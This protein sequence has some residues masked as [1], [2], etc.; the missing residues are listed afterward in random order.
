MDAK[1]VAG[2]ARD[3][4][5][6]VSSSF[7]A[8]LVIAFLFSLVAL[9]GLDSLLAGMHAERD[10]GHTIGDLASVLHPRQAEERAA[11][12]IGTWRGWQAEYRTAIGPDVI[13]PAWVAALHALIDSALLV[14]TYTL[15]LYF[16]FRGI[17]RS[18]TASEGERV[19]AR[20]AAH[21]VLTLAAFD[22][23]ENA[24][25]LVVLRD[26]WQDPSLK[27]R[28]GAEAY[29]LT[30]AAD[31]KY[32]VAV[33][34]VVA[35][36]G[37]GW[38]RF[39]RW[40]ENE[41][42]S[43]RLALSRLRLH[44]VAAILFAGVLLGH[45][46]LP[47][48]IRRWSAAQLGWAIS[49]TA[50]FAFV[51]WVS[52]GKLFTDGP[53]TKGAG[54][55]TR[56]SHPLLYFACLLV[57]VGAS[58]DAITDGLEWFPWALAIPAAFVL[59]FA[60]AG[61]ILRGV[62]LEAT[63]SVAEVPED[64]DG[65][66][67]SLI[68]PAAVVV[69]LG[70]AVFRASFAYSI[71]LE[72]WTWWVLVVI[73]SILVGGAVGLYVSVGAP[74]KPTDEHVLLRILRVPVVWSVI[75]AAVAFVILRVKVGGELNGSLLVTTG[76]FLG[77]AGWFT[78]NL[79]S[80]FSTHERKLVA[81]TI[82][83]GV[84]LL[85]LLWTWIIANPWWIA[86]EL[87]GVAILA[88]FCA[89]L[90]FGAWAVIHFSDGVPPPPAL[91]VL[92]FRHTPIVALGLVWLVLA[93]VLD[94]GGFHD[95]R[96]DRDARG[97]R[98]TL[99]E[100]W[101]CWKQKNGLE[102]RSLSTCSQPA[103]TEVADE[104]AQVTPMI[105]VATTGGGIRA[106]IWTSYV[107]DC[108][109]E[110]AVDHAT[111]RSPCVTGPRAATFRRSDD[112]FA[113]SGISGGSM[114]LASYAAYLT[115][116]HGPEPANWQATRLDADSLSASVAWWLFVE[117]PWAF[118][119]FGDVKDRAAV[120]ERG[121]ERDWRSASGLNSL[122]QPFLGLWKKPH[123]PLLLL[124]GTNVV[125]GCRFNV[126]TLDTRIAAQG[127]SDPDALERC[128]S[129]TAFDESNATTA[130]NLGTTHVRESSALAATRDLTDFL[131]GGAVDIP[132]STAALLSGRFPF[133]SPAG[134]IEQPCGNHRVSYVVDGGYL[135]TSGASPVVQ[136][137]SRLEPSILRWDRQNPK[138]CIIPFLIQID[139]GPPGRQ[140][141]SKRP[142]ELL[143]PLKGLFAS[144]IGRAADSRN[145]AALLFN[146][147][148]GT[149]T[150]RESGD[151]NPTALADRYAHFVNLAHPGPQPPLGWT[152]SAFSRE[153]LRG[154]LGQSRNVIA[155]NEVRSW[156][157]AARDGR[158][159]CK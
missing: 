45:E 132:L 91:R 92:R 14:V 43:F 110:V 111:D 31:I 122:G 139:N 82:G 156:F 117:S 55:G 47:D 89:V 88:S 143:V 63:P 10:V 20:R 151:A 6:G 87:G 65:H 115:E 3:A 138:R 152:L 36:V 50:V 150:F 33:V 19:L 127:E 38:L 22:L 135:D 39:K 81:W 104:T 28:V 133:V 159:A 124:N 153:D 70:L 125:D 32:L 76:V 41:G 54:D 119:R 77:Y 23:V 29:V 34:V 21:L 146:T 52:A 49:G 94:P 113:M 53:R 103:G 35:A 72:Q 68:L 75:G 105:F 66:R 17:V 144:R 25:E 118:G 116:K 154:Q 24:L 57:F 5:R 2:R 121:W 123:V 95:I 109:F 106:A 128:R 48:I 8:T 149:T 85:G 46:Q 12:V 9:S 58:V 145:A 134:R 79:L 61:R 73:A 100:A 102:A 62:E 42:A 74:S 129:T 136:L 108:A 13:S 157:T 126:S 120:L 59:A 90:A 67:L 101:E 71:Y 27:V 141:L 112:I 1:A 158:L 78:Y 11:D 96:V 131:C 69:A 93:S 137:V 37:L 16:F 44:L 30:A 107:L 114:G 15:G 155:M 60:L 98:V 99:N 97:Q 83:G 140:N 18:T 142:Q 148:F 84:A 86:A 51:L 26:G 7:V 130:A 147:R 40:H 4:A 56:R 64:S 80:R